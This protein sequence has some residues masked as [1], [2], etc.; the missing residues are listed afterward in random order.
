MSKKFIG[1]LAL[2][3]LAP[4]IAG[5]VMFGVPSI[6]NKI[7]PKSDNS[8]YVKQIEELEKTNSS[9][10]S[11]ND[12]LKQENTTLKQDNVTF[13]GRIQNLNAELTT[14]NN[15]IKSKDEAITSKEKEIATLT[16]D[17]EKLQADLDKYKELAGSDVNY[18]ELVNTLQTQLSEKT[19]ALTTAT[20]E[21]EQLRTDK[22]NL[23]ARVTELETE[24]NQLI[25]ELA[26]YRS[27]DNIDKLKV[28]N[29]NGRW[30]QE[31]TFK[32]YYTIENGVATLN[33]NEDKG[34]L[35]NIYGQM[36]IMM[37]TSGG[38]PVTLS[39][40][41]T[42]FT[43]EDGVKYSKFYTNTIRSV[44]PNYSFAG[45][46]SKDTTTIK[47]N[48]DNTITLTDSTGTYNGA[49]VV[50]A[51]EKNVG[52]NLT[53]INT[54]TATYQI[55]DKSVEKIYTI[56]SNENVLVDSD[57]VGYEKIGFV[58]GLLLSAK[59]NYSYTPSA[60][61]YY[62]VLIKTSEKILIK[63]GNGSVSLHLGVGALQKTGVSS[64]STLKINNESKPNIVANSVTSFNFYNTTSNNVYTNLFEFH[65]Y[66]SSIF[67]NLFKIISFGNKDVEILSVENVGVD[68]NTYPLFGDMLD[69]FIKCG[70]GTDFFVNCDSVLDYVVGIYSNEE[71][72]IA[73]TSETATVNDITAT[74]YD[75]TAKTDG[76]DIYQ[77][78]TIKYSTTVNETTTEH[79]LVLELKNKVL[80]SSLLDNTEIA[81]SKSN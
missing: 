41:G 30:Y 75:V 12:K 78:V 11:E 4:T 18:I 51:K 17:K 32:S 40:D 81:F 68:F 26:N 6:R 56:T 33:A 15:T 55:N 60:T 49:Y 44:T 16:S 48:A 45:T 46:Y 66:E 47:I 58:S 69:S 73:L 25:E 37:N 22:E 67:N 64:Y 52:G 62:K 31:G 1:G 24:R 14:A 20:A 80:L 36:Y 72:T 3:L 65:F 71:N 42:Y 5:G 2:G 10:K 9:Y 57:N 21:L 23:T 8:E 74:S 50:T 53:I 7:M 38:K 79:T 43:T 54:I 63:S 13:A 70:N 28:E 61:G 59:T 35:N 77:T 39:D 76:T 19:T 27:M 34:L 29:F